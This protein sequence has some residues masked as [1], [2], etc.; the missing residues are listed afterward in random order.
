MSKT[1]IRIGI[2][3]KAALAHFAALLRVQRKERNLTLNELADRLGISIPTV[4]KMLDGSPSVAIG[5]YFE[6]ARILGVPL[7]DPD[8]DRFAMTASRT[9]E[10]ESLL[11]QRI[12]A[13]QQEI[14][15]D[16]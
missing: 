15:D 3:A 4:R 1:S 7:F 10:M 11:P 6:A 16:F 14:H 12:R 8:P 13:R 5:S 2:V 9:A